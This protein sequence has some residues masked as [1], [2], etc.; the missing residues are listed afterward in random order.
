M[1]SEDTPPESPEVLIMV[2]RVEDG[3]VA[4]A[5][6]SRVTPADPGAVLTQ[7]L[8]L[9]GRWA[10]AVRSWHARPHWSHGKQSPPPLNAKCGSWV[11]G[12]GGL[13][14]SLALC[15]DSDP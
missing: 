4:A 13:P 12:V 15:S 14:G 7:E 8:A 9:P 10:Q 6:G 1:T 3:W 11:R 2:S 5:S